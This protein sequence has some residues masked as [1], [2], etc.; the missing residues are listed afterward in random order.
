MGGKI[1]EQQKAIKLRTKG[2]SI[3]EI[4]HTLQVSKGSVSTWVRS[5]PLNRNHIQRLKNRELEGGKKG[6]RKLQARWTE[7][8]KSHPK[9]TPKPK[10][11]RSIDTFFDKWTPDMAYVLGFFAADGC[12]YVNKRGSHYI[13]FYST[14]RQLILMVKKILGASN[15][16]E[17]YQPKGKRKE[18]HTLQIGSH[19][20]FSRLVELG[21]TPNKSLTLNFPKVPN[22]ALSDF[23]RGYF[24]GD[25][26][27]HYGLHNRKNRKRKQSIFMSRFTCGNRNFLE[28]LQQKLCQVVKLG[29]GSLHRHT[30]VW[31]LA[32]AG[33]DTGQL[34]YF[35]YPKPNVHCLLRK[36][37]KFE[38]GIAKTS[39]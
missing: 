23:V 15:T 13:A 3:N 5:V 6:R 25:G 26:C 34:Y 4:A 39:Y 20:A 7:Y 21:F 16:I 14:D 36:R 27:I 32:Y 2:R 17:R 33:K 29:K 18:R 31:D 24:D 12:M 8:R 22:S 1:A 30:T 19:Q 38:E 35:I 10:P 9:P 11:Q 28:S 37:K